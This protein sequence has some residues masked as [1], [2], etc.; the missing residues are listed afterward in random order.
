MTSSST[1]QRDL[2][3]AYK[4]RPKPAGVF[5]IKNTATG[6]MLLGS[7]LNL[8]GSLN[9]HRFMLVHGSHY[10][11]AMQA[12]W[13]AHGAAAFR[14]EILAVVEIRDDPAFNLAD[15]LAALEARWIAE[16]QPVAP[17]G[18]NTEAQIRDV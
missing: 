17:H 9:R 15:A 12:E 3:R 4:E 1:R 6:K 18:Y 5:Q 16:I 14:F 8:D 2:K 11:K 10:N 7:S 13:K